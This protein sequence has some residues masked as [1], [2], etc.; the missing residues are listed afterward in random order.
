[1]DPQN[2][3]QLGIVRH[4]WDSVENQ[5]QMIIDLRTDEEK[6]NCEEKFIAASF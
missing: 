1:M 3:E 4:I 2:L 6:Q 5:D